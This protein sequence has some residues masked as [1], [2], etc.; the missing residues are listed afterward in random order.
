MKLSGRE[1]KVESGISEVDLIGV[2]QIAK[3]L[4]IKDN[5]VEVKP[6]YLSLSP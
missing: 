2:Q 1:G 3:V 5:S 4:M 6:S